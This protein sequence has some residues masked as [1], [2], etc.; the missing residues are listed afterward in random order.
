MIIINR[1]NIFNLEKSEYI[2]RKIIK[3]KQ[4]NIFFNFRLGIIDS[5]L[6][7]RL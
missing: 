5:F 6:I 2:N 7:I 3:I 1:I 4:K